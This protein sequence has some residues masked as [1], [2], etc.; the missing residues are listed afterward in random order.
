MKELRLHDTDKLRNHHHVKL[1]IF[2]ELFSKVEPLVMPRSTK[3]KNRRLFL[4]VYTI[5]EFNV[6]SKAEC[7][8]LNLAH[9]TE[10][11]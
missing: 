3:L 11:I 8:Q 4:V 9:E 5:E 1:P 6:D 2:E 10:T 7:D